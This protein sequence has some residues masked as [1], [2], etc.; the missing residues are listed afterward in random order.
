METVEKGCIFCARTSSKQWFK[1]KTVCNACYEKNRINSKPILNLIC[2]ECGP[3]KAKKL[4]NGLCQR[5]YHKARDKTKVKHC[6]WCQETKKSIFIKQL[7]Q[8]CYSA[9]KRADKPEM[10]SSYAD[11]NRHEIRSRNSKW[12]AANPHSRNAMAAKRRAAKLKRTPSWSDLDA[13]KEF[14][15][16]CPPGYEVDHILP[17]QGENISG[18]HMLDNL[19][20]LDA[21]D[22]SSKGNKFDGTLANE[23]WRV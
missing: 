19:Q 10:F 18:F 5:C 7:C 12:A 9:K 21:S 8:K 23:G 15:L 11:K 4:T 13:I 6:V 14:Y 3:A 22:N 2:V 16:N 1:D 20:Y 17:L